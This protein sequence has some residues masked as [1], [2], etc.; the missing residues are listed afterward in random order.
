MCHL[1]QV[2]FEEAFNNS[3]TGISNSYSDIHAPTGLY[4]GL[5]KAMSMYGFIYVD[6][7]YEGRLVIKVDP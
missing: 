7:L 4:G 1:E 6:K 3:N 2:R 5:R